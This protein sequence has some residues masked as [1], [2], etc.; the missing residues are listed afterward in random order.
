[1][2]WIVNFL[3]S[4][5]SLVIALVKFIFDGIQS[6]VML[7]VMIPEYISYLGNMVSILPSWIIVFLTG[8]VAITVIWTIRRAI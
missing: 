3:K 8:I 2:T 7:I 6:I 4:I 5:G 1:M